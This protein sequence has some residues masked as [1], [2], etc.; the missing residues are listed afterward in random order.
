VQQV[1]F[2][3]LGGLTLLGYG[4]VVNLPPWDFGKLLGIYVALF[5]LV[6]QSIN[7]FGFGQTPS[8]SIWVGASQTIG[9]ALLKRRQRLFQ[10]WHRVRDGTMMH[11][12][13]FETAVVALRQG[14]NSELESA[15]QY[16]CPSSLADWK[17]S[18]I[19]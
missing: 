5:F 16:V 19:N 9:E 4:I 11:R 3:L 15:V 1:E 12:A 17:L 14:F 2:I 18:S 7:Y 13:D 6:A 8:I 10:W